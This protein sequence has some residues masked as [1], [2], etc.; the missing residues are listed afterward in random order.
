MLKIIISCSFA[1]AQAQKKLSEHFRFSVWDKRGADE[2]RWLILIGT[3]VSLT[4]HLP[5][6]YRRKWQKEINSEIS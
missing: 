3:V 5:N 4:S 1:D 2:S 6:I